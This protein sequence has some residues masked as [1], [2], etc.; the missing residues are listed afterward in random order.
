VPSA[1][2]LR[3]GAVAPLG[4]GYSMAWTGTDRPIAK[5]E[6]TDLEFSVRDA[7]GATVQLEPYL[8]MAAH[9]VL[10]RA[11]DSVFIHLHP[12]GTV[13]PVAQT[14]FALRDRGDTTLDGHV[15]PYALRQLAM[16]DMG[17]MPDTRGMRLTG[18][19]SVPYEFP[20]PG[21]Y[22]MWVQVKPATRVLTAAFDVDVR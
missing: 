11:D 9:A 22:R 5:G 15:T 2:L 1:T 19:F 7:H 17:A 18:N 14:V 21:R 6:L 13:A 8:G 3:R 4:D 16:S 10:L 12:M 20:K